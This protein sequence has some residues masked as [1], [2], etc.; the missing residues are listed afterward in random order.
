MTAPARFWCGFR[1]LFTLQRLVRRTLRSLSVALRRFP[2]VSSATTAHPEPLHGDEHTE[3]GDPEAVVLNELDHRCPPPPSGLPPARV[4][5]SSCGHPRRIV[6]A[7]AVPRAVASGGGQL[8]LKINGLW[9]YAGAERRLDGSGFDTESGG[10]SSRPCP[11]DFL[12]KPSLPN[13]ITEMERQ[14]SG[15]RVAGRW[16]V[17]FSG[18]AWSDTSQL[19]PEDTHGLSPVPERPRAGVPGGDGVV[20][21]ASAAAS[22]RPPRARG[23]AGLLDLL[24]N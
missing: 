4:P 9:S 6:F 19:D 21:H 12:S 17:A 16:A 13:F 24:L 8:A 2:P 7:I 14:S 11:E 5:G 23:H 3:Q 20:Q 22:R 10:R 15:S 1:S 18:F